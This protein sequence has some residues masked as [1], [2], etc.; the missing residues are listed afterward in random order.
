MEVEKIDYAIIGGGVVGLA[1]AYEII[2]RYPNSSVV[3]L[4]KESGPAKHQSGRNSGVIHSG[5]YYKPGSL[6]AKNC[7]LGKQLLIDFAQQYQVPYKLCGKVIVATAEKELS[8]LQ[9]IYERGVAN[10]IE[11]ELIGP[12]KLKELEPHATALKAIWVKEAGVMDYAALARTLV[13]VCESMGARVLFD[14]KVS[15]LVDLKEGRLIRCS[16]GEFLAKIVINACGLHSD[17]VLEL[18]DKK[19]RVNRIVPFRGEYYAVK[20][21]RDYLCKS[22][23]YPV[24]NPDFPFLGVH[25]TR[26]VHSLVECGP[27]A[28]LALAREG[29][30][31][32]NIN[33]KDIWDTLT[34]AGFWKFSAKY[35][36]EG[37]DEILRSAS[38]SYFVSSLGR[39]IPEIKAEDLT[40]APSG[41][42]AQAM[43]PSGSLVDDFIIQ[44]TNNCIHILNAPSPAATS[45]LSIARYIG[46]LLSE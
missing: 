8:A 22:L 26:D 23:I 43:V 27:N 19:Q 46:D 25:F 14:A 39:L 40:T 34:Y 5:I 38:K 32:G 17:R 13:Q 35:W 7:R 18:A 9:N 37:W 3:L 16:K 10:S 24:P 12:E 4:E 36:R 6:K 15:G 29:Y 42:R 41:V 30:T 31:W 2:K 20:P 21:E 1:S 11:C 45:C 28:V 33:L 44:R